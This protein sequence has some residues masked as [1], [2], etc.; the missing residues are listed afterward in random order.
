MYQ[1]GSPAACAQPG[2]PAVKE[3]HATD[4]DQT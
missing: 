3:Q 4:G 2:N 1:E